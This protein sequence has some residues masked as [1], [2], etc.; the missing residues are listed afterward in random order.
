M[1]FEDNESPSLLFAEQAGAP[2]T[3]ASG[4]W[5]AYFKSGG[6]YVV[7]D[8]GT[9][10]GPLA[11][12]G[13]GGGSSLLAV[14]TYAPGSTTVKSITG[15]SLA[16]VDATNMKVTFTAPA[17]GNVVVDQSFYIDENGGAPTGEFYIGLRESTTDIA[18]ARALRNDAGQAYHT[19]RHYLTGVTSGSHTYKTSAAV[20]TGVTG[21]IV[22]GPGA[23]VGDFPK[24]IICVWGAP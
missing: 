2:T 21:R 10:T 4:F 20:S 3:P 1:K 17:S 22:L 18:V 13:V 6:L 24:A 23:A 11:P 16:D 5:R 7:D 12:S 8:A 19:I 14:A 15:T 9:E